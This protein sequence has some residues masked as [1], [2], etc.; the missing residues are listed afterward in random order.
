MKQGAQVGRSVKV[1]PGE[2]QSG[3]LG[4]SQNPIDDDMILMRSGTKS[5]I[6]SSS[7]VGSTYSNHAR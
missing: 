1:V 3:Y 4:G 5:G 2:R 6:Y 7:L